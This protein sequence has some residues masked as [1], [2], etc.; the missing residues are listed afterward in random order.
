[1]GKH[2]LQKGSSKSLSCTGATN[3]ERETWK[4]MSHLT[5]GAPGVS[6]VFAT[7]KRERAPDGRLRYTQMSG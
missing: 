6:N 2:L 7:D 1:M 3:R 5:G 4:K